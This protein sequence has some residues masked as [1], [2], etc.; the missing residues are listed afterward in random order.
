MAKITENETF[1][2]FLT[3]GIPVSKRVDGKIFIDK[4]KT[5]YH[6]R[7]SYPEIIRKE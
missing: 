6:T 2:R 4:L 3:E 5:M 7:I 1:H